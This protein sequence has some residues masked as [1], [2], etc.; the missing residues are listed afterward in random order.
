VKNKFGSFKNLFIVVLVGWIG[1]DFYSPSHNSIQPQNTPIT[2]FG[3]NPETHLEDLDI[4]ERWGR[5][6]GFLDSVPE[7]HPYFDKYYVTFFKNVG[8]CEFSG[9]GPT[10]IESV[11]RDRFLNLISQLTEVYGN[12]VSFHGDDGRS[13]RIPFSNDLLVSSERKRVYWEGE[14]FEKS[15]FPLTEINLGYTF[16]T[17]SVDYNYVAVNFKLSNYDECRSGSF[18]SFN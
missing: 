1:Y 18:N 12:P 14:E 2:V 7:P 5:F 4:G 15:Y 11:G 10:H 17:D 6:G 8:I 16:D 9:M 13:S 3:L